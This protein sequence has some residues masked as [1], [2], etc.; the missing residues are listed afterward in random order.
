MPVLGGPFGLTVSGVRVTAESRIP[1]SPFSHIQKLLFK[2]TRALVALSAFASSLS[3]VEGAR[4][5]SSITGS[6]D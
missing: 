2:S 4:S 6:H 5:L 1:G 3:K